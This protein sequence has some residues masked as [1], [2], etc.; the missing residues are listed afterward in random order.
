MKRACYITKKEKNKLKS[1][2]SLRVAVEELGSQN[3][4]ADTLKVSK[5]AVSNW[6]A[7]RKRISIQNA[8]K[9]SKIVNNNLQA[10][11]FRP[12]IFDID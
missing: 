10:S 4:L 8:L 6:L 9:L 11:D 5:S 12:D 2:K 1:I 7:G 3:E